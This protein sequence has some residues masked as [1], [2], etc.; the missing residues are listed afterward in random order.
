MKNILFLLAQR[1][2]LNHFK[3]SKRIRLDRISQVFKF[4]RLSLWQKYELL[5]G[6][7]IFTQKRAVGLRHRDG[8]IRDPC[9]QQEK[10][11]HL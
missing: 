9:L 4:R 8:I 11:L 5:T 1:N 2:Q 3:A 10:P 7:K 6:S